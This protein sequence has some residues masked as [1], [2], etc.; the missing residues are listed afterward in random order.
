MYAAISQTLFNLP[1]S[2]FVQVVYM[3][4]KIAPIV[5]LH[6][7]FY[8]FFH[9]S[10]NQGFLCAAVT[11]I[12]VVFLLLTFKLCV[13]GAYQMRTSIGCFSHYIIGQGHGQFLRFLYYLFCAVI[14]QRALNL[15]LSYFVH[16][17]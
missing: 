10:I 14:T 17:Y 9:P 1:L 11:Q 7:S 13:R 16:S 3:L 6:V 12:L 4:V 8:L 2:Y 15:Q 5:H